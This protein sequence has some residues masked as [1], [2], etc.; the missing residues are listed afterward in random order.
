MFFFLGI[1]LAKSYDLMVNDGEPSISMHPL[2]NVSSTFTF[3]TT[4][5][6][7]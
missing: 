5:L 2:A 1:L 3:Q 7:I 4:N 6:K